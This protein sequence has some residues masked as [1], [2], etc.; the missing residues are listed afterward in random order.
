MVHKELDH[1]DALLE[2]HRRPRFAARRVV[3]AESARA[4]SNFVRT[5]GWDPVD[6]HLKVSDVPSL[7]KLLGGAHLYGSDNLVPL[8]ELIQNSTDAVHARSLIDPTLNS[9]GTVTVSILEEDGSHWLEVVDNG[10]GMSER[11]LTEN[12]LDFGRSF[13]SSE[14]V[15]REFPGLLAKG[16]APVG[17][18]GIGFFSVFML[19]DVVRVSSRR[20]DASL[21]STKT[22][23]FRAGLELRPILRAASPKELVRDGGTRVIVRLKNAPSATN[24]LSNRK[25]RDPFGWLDNSEKEDRLDLMIGALCPNVDVRVEAQVKGTKQRTIDSGDWQRI[26]GFAL[27]CRVR[28][29]EESESRR[30][31]AYGQLVRPLRDE[32]GVYGRACVD[33]NE[34]V[35]PKPLQC[36]VTVGG[37]RAGTVAGMAG[38]LKGSTDV[39]TRNTATPT[40][41]V[42]ALTAWAEEQASLLAESKVFSQKE[43]LRGASILMRFGAHPGNLPIARTGD[44]FL[45]ASE[46]RTLMQPR[47]VVKVHNGTSVGYDADKDSCHERV[48]DIEFSSNPTMLFLGESQPDESWPAGCFRTEDGKAPYSFYKV[49]IATLKEAWG[50]EFDEY[51]SEEVV[52]D[53]DSVEILREVAVYERSSSG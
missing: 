17:R 1:V 25:M 14:A 29:C 32:N 37:F 11:T 23:E 28:E 47:T 13:W 15:R 48:F 24:F 33:C 49:F 18:F 9:R 43:K 4:F 40:V 5:E 31:I 36:V 51:D 3:G 8:R 7:V 44:E 10:I 6:A 42:L 39:V 20:F 52:G 21:D 27:L 46:L 50:T 41:P 45:N 26:S 53:A 22:L 30:L 35:F 38:L 19:G 16:L 12:L 2:N 34:G